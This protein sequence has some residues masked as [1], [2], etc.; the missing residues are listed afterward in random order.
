MSEEVTCTKGR[1]NCTYSSAYVKCGL[2]YHILKESVI[3]K[4]KPT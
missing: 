3:V 1:A 2:S 4:R